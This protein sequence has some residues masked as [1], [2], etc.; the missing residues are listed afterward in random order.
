MSSRAA[1]IHSPPSLTEVRAY[2]QAATEVVPDIAPALVLA[3]VTGMRRGELVR[4]R[5]S[6]LLPEHGK[7]TVDSSIGGDGVTPTRRVRD[8]AL[9]PTTMAILVGHS[10]AMD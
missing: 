7:V 3:A 10:A 2:M 6:R 1:E 4:L 9:D 5:R 8:V